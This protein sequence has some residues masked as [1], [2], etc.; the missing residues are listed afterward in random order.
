[1]TAKFP[2]KVDLLSVYVHNGVAG[3]DYVN[4]RRPSQL[5]FSFP[6]GTSKVIDLQDVHDKQ[7]FELKASG[8]DEVTIKV[9]ATVGPADAPVAISEIE[10]FKKGTPPAKPS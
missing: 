1:V 10:F 6:D 8:V 2:E 5:Q 3:K 9:L 4:F 7:L